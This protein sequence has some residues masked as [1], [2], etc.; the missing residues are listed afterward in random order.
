MARPE[1]APAD[2][3]E[4]QSRRLLIEVKDGFKVIE[5]CIRDTETSGKIDEE[6]R[7]FLTKAFENPSWERQL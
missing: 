3:K 7:S 2:I 4:I 1:F 5:I 6:M